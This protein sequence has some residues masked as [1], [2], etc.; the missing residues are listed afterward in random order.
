MY[1]MYNNNNYIN[2]ICVCAC[3]CVSVM[4]ARTHV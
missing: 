4:R 1:N 3:A 2:N